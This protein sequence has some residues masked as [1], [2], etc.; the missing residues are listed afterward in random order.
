[1]VT[2]RFLST[3]TNLRPHVNHAQHDIIDH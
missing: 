2:Y 1:M 3:I